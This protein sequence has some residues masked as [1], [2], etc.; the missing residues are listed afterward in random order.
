MGW[1]VSPTFSVFNCIESSSH[2]VSGEAIY[3]FLFFC[4][5]SSV[6]KKL[7]LLILLQSQLVGKF[8]NQKKKKLYIYLMESHPYSIKCDWINVARQWLSFNTYFW[9]ERRSFYLCGVRIYSPLFVPV[10]FNWEFMMLLTLIRHERWFS[11]G[12]LGIDQS[13]SRA[14]KSGW[15]FI[16]YSW[17][18]YFSSPDLIIIYL[19]IWILLCTSQ[20]TILNWHKDYDRILWQA[21]KPKSPLLMIVIGL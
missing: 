3:G 9:P 7:L 1:S 16:S 17:L 5:D 4:P 18:I 19:S 21:L 20:P 8:L 14:T 15:S 13:S 2:F 11:L 10:M 12:V 6:I